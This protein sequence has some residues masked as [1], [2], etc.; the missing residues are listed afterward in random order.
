MNEGTIIVPSFPRNSINKFQNFFVF[1]SES[2]WIL[3]WYSEKL[4]LED[5]PDHN[6]EGDRI[7]LEDHRRYG[8]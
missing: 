3:S 5:L 4:K 6:L 1:E 8:D 2:G 7:I